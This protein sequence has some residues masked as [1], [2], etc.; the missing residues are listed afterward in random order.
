MARWIRTHQGNGHTP[1]PGN[2]MTT[3][4]DNGVNRGYDGEV[5]STVNRGVRRAISETQS[6][7]DDHQ[8]SVLCERHAKCAC[9]CKKAGR[10]VP[11]HVEGTH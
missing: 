11:Q 4:D 9:D 6:D 3:C 1:K 8:P 2:E 5:L 10:R 7:S